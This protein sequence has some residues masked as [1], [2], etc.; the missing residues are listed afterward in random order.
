MKKST[1]KGV[2][3]KYV[4]KAVIISDGKVLLL[5]RSNYLEK[6]KNEWDLPG[7]HIHNDESLKQGLFREVFEETGLI[8]KKAAEVFK[9]GNDSFFLVQ[10]DIRKVKLSSEHISHK[11]F[12]IK[13]LNDLDSLTTYYREAILK[14]I[15]S[16]KGTK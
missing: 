9:S 7:G 15:E 2:D 12:K 8:V 5:K 1:K 14:C 11:L 4:A 6:H 13:D 3:S 10:M 16:I